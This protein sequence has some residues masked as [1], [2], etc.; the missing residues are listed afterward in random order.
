MQE[1]NGLTK[2]EAAARLKKDGYNEVPEAPFS[3]T[4]QIL[5]RL[6]EPN[7]W[8]LEA[9]LFVEIILG[10]PFQAAFI[11]VLL[12]FA[13]TNG[14]FQARK[15]HRNLSSLSQDLTIKVAVKRSN[16]WLTIPSREL[17]V[18]DIVNL[19]QGNLIPE[20]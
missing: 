15:A 10:K 2:E 17:V 19:Q 7:A 3:L 11:I 1:I 13:A 18:G 8:I 4:R 9:A 14:A 6:W 16:H 12:L 5:K 20:D